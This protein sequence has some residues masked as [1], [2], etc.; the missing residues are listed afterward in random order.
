MLIIRKHF[1]FIN[2]FIES[3]S[4]RAFALA[5]FASVIILSTLAATMAH[6]G[7]PAMNGRPWDTPILLDGAWRIAN[8]QIPHLDFYSHLGALPYYISF[9]GMKPGHPDVSSITY[10]SISLMALLACASILVLWSRTT[11]FYLFLFTLFLGFLVITPRPLGDPYDCNDYAMIYNRLGEALLAL[12][13]IIVFL[14]PRQDRR[15]GW[16]DWF[17]SMIAGL[18]LG[19][20]FFVKL[21]YFCIGILFLALSGVLCL[22]N[23]PL[24]V[25]CVFSSVIFSAIFLILSGI[26]MGAMV[27]DF[28][29]MANA[30]SPGSRIIA[31]AIQLIKHIMLLPILLIL[32]LEWQS[33]APKSTGWLA[34]LQTWVPPVAIFGS[35]VLLVASNTQVGEMPLLA[36]AALCGAEQIRR[37]TAISP[38]GPVFRAERSLAVLCLFMLFSLPTLGIDIKSVSHVLHVSKPANAM[39][40]GLLKT[41]N[42][43]DF[44][45]DAKGVQA[46][47]S[48]GYVDEL[49]DGISLLRRHMDPGMRLCSTLFSNPFHLALGLKPAKGG[50]T[51]WADC[52]LN[53]RSHP[54]LSHM[55]GNSTHII[56]SRDGDD[57]KSV[58]GAEWDALKL[59]IVEKSKFF[60]L[61]KIHRTQG[62]ATPH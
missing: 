54:A 51:C 22:R 27:A 30:Q 40:T 45:F 1:H 59:E 31:L 52:V 39:D 7:A 3:E 60:T 13:A 58:Y 5:V 34:I 57:V 38:T 15:H 41:T 53:S 42:L 28:H 8:G 23:L 49:N 47:N 55:I 4:N 36:V 56:V 25:A 11:P 37:Q 35:A 48:K 50:L 26:H 32:A 61:Y 2:S 9:L 44:R 12:F 62:D 10:G 21:N 43:Q 6:L 46:T 16:L 18:L 24:I 19:S 14:P 17:E 20:L 33:G 29:I